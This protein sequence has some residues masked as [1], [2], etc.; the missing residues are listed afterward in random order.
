[1][2]RNH[3][4]HS[5]WPLRLAPPV[6]RVALT[7]NMPG[8]QSS[9]PLLAPGT[10]LRLLTAHRP[11]PRPGAPCSGLGYDTLLLGLSSSLAL[12]DCTLPTRRPGMRAHQGLI[13]AGEGCTSP[14]GMATSYHLE[15]LWLKTAVEPSLVQAWQRGPPCPP[16]VR[17]IP[18]ISAEEL[19]S[20]Q[21][22]RFLLSPHAVWHSQ[23]PAPGCSQIYLGLLPS[24]HQRAGMGAPG[25]SFP[26]CVYLKL[27]YC[28][29]GA[30]AWLS[31]LS[32][33]LL[34]S[35]QVTI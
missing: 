1:M 26:V 19:N 23:A 2:G 28:R 15:T 33:R 35:D 4:P 8:H 11:S 5:S 18:K 34:V 24:S 22:L 32:I 13:T 9:N 17:S 29:P 31:R 3:S 27:I 14:L 16:A 12:Q 25:T 7:N 20:R 6:D 21:L 30:P 10:W